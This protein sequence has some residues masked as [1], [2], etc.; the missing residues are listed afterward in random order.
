MSKFLR[1]AVRAPRSTRAS[2]AENVGTRRT[3]PT[4]WLLGFATALGCLL[5]LAGIGGAGAQV[6]A[7]AADPAT[8]P[9]FK[10]K[11]RGKD[12]FPTTKRKLQ[13]LQVVHS[14]CAGTVGLV[15]DVAFEGVKTT[16]FN[17]SNPTNGGG[18][19]ARFDPTPVLSTTVTLTNGCLNAHLSAIVGSSIYG[20]SRLT[21]LQVTLTPVG[22][23]ARKHM[24]GHYETP[25]GVYGPSVALTAEPDVDMYASDFYQTIG[26]GGIPPG[27]YKVDVWW[28]GGPA[29]P[30]G[31][32]GAGFDLKL[33]ATGPTSVPNGTTFVFADSTIADQLIAGA[34][35]TC[36]TGKPTYGGGWTLQGTI[37]VGNNLDNF[38]VLT[39]SPYGSMQ[40][41]QVSI[42]RSGP[43]PNGRAWGVRVFAIC[44]L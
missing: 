13:K 38:V 11:F 16:A 12:F 41:W 14:D 28:A 8:A 35:P 34:N 37:G 22:G 20:V 25:Y 39:N 44:G 1:N 4:R 32:I 17:W 6:M 31:A 7:H 30:G 18:E 26:P 43:T 40:G 5:A 23:G 42:R 19:G 29:T 3:N 33:Y 2:A 27:T 24:V 9:E 15:K 21:M 10:N 36:P